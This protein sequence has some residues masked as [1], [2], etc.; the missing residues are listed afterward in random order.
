MNTVKDNFYFVEDV[1]KMLGLSRSKCYKIIKQLNQELNRQGYITVPG[2]VS[3]QYYHQRF[4]CG[5]EKGEGPTDKKVTGAK[6][7]GIGRTA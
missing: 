5:P 2:R 7:P 3:K 6:R 1:M 4:Y